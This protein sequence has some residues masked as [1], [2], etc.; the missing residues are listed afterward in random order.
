M[1]KS[2]EKKCKENCNCFSKKISVNIKKEESLEC[3]GK[4][5]FTSTETKSYDKHTKIPQSRNSKD[6]PDLDILKDAFKLLLDDLENLN[7]YTECL[8]NKEDFD[9]K[10]SSLVYQINN[11]I[12]DFEEV[13][14]EFEMF[15]EIYDKFEDQLKNMDMLLIQI[16]KE[17]NF[18]QVDSENY[19][20]EKD[21]LLCD[22]IVFK[23][24]V[25][26]VYKSVFTG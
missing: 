17:I 13:K 3:E 5:F 9:K 15:I 16:L 19:D 18:L 20:D 14:S 22:I 2:D 26:S 12:E 6:D 1:T 8:S 23:T 25:E 4:K 21:Q 10:I 7:G 11:V 24:N